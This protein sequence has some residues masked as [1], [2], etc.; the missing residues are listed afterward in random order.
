V[1]VVA[2]ADVSVAV[3]VVTVTL[4]T[5]VPVTV[6]VVPVAIVSVSVVV[7]SVNDVVVVD[8]Q[9][10]TKSSQQ[11]FKSTH[12]SLQVHRAGF[13]SRRD[14]PRPP[15]TPSQVPVLFG[16]KVVV[17]T[18]SFLHSRGLLPAIGLPSSQALQ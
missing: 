12:S 2:V 7:V 9:S 18:T 4:V 1:V 17:E 13:P 10:C 11:S 14:L 6:V 8:T 16:R 3:V 5:V 15:H